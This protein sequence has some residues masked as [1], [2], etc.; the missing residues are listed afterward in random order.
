MQ[1]F[2]TNIMEPHVSEEKGIK[3]Y[4]PTPNL[5]FDVT[6]PAC[7]SLSPAIYRN[8]FPFVTAIDCM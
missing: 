1:S 7:R 3:N 5:N 4:S 6:V 8:G 2:R